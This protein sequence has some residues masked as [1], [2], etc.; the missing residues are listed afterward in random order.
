MPAP[1]MVTAA[2]V[3]ARHSALL[4]AEQERR[5]RRL[6]AMQRAPSLVDQIKYVFSGV[7]R[8]AFGLRA[9][10][11]ALAS[12][13]R[14]AL[15]EAAHCAQFAL[16]QL[17]QTY[18][19]TRKRRQGVGGARH[20]SWRCHRQAPTRRRPA[21]VPGSP[22]SGL[23]R[24]LRCATRPAHN[25]GASGPNRR[26]SR[27]P[28]IAAGQ[29]A[30]LAGTARV[31][32]GLTIRGTLFLSSNSSSTLSA[33]WVA[34][35]SGGTLQAGSAA[36]PVPAGITATIELQNG[37]AHP[38]A[39]RKALALLAGGTLEL[40]GAKGLA[41]PWAR[42]AA[43]AAKG[44]ATLHLDSDA[45]AAG[46]A[47]GDELAIASTDY[48][49]YQTE[50]VTITAG[51]LAENNVAVDIAGHAFFFEDGSETGNTLRGNLGML[52]R[53]KL[54]GARLGSDR[55]GPGGDLS[56][57]WIT[58]PDNTFEG[59]AAAATEGWG[60]FVHTRLAPRGLSAA[61]WPALAPHRTPL[62]SF[63]NNSAHSCRLC[64]E[65]EADAVD[66][67]DSLPVVPNSAPANW[68]PRNADGSWAEMRIEGFTCHHSFS[69]GMWVRMG[70]MR[71]VRT[72]WADQPEALQLA[73]TGTHIAPPGANALEDVLLVGVS[74]NVGDPEG[75][76]RFQRWDNRQGRSVAPQQ[77]I[78]S[79]ITGFKLYD[80]PTTIR[81][82]T[83]RSWPA[84]TA[85]LAVRSNNA[86]QMA[87]GTSVSGFR[88]ERVS[89]RFL[90][91]DSGGDGG[92]TTTLRDVD[93]SLS[94]Y[95]GATLLPYF[96]ASS[97]GFFSAPGCASHPAYG[98][99]CPHKYINLE[100]G[101]WDW[102]GGG[103]PAAIT[104]TH[105]NLSPGRA[106]AAQRLPSL[107]G[108]QLAQKSGRGGRYYNAAASV[109]GSYLVTWG[110]GSGAPGAPARAFAQCSSCGPGDEVE[111]I[112]CYPGGTT[113]GAAGVTRGSWEFLP[114]QQDAAA[115]AA[116]GSFASLAAMR[117]ATGQGSRYYFD[118]ASGLLFLRVQQSAGWGGQE[119]D[120][121][122]PPGGCAVLVVH[123][124]PAG[125]AHTPQQ[126]EAWL[127]A[128]PGGASTNAA[129][130]PFLSAALPAPLFNLTT[131]CPGLPAFGCDC[132][133]HTGC[134]SKECTAA[135]RACCDASVDSPLGPPS[136]PPLASP[137]PSSASPVP[138]SP[139]PPPRPSPPASATAACSTVSAGGDFCAPFCFTK[140]NRNFQTG[141]GF[142]GFNP[143]CKSGGLG[144]LGSQEGCRLCHLAGATGNDPYF[145]CPACVCEHY[146]LAPSLCDAQGRAGLLVV[147][148]P[149]LPKPPT[150][151]AAARPKPPP[152]LRRA[153]PPSLRP[154]HTSHLLKAEPVRDSSPSPKPSPRPPPPS[155]RPLK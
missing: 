88:P 39:G 125:A 13:A 3:S 142:L 122:C 144:C 61:S 23:P 85:P 147:P 75:D 120:G 12:A 28:D 37:S 136:P 25:S 94:G 18:T 21:A 72:A 102:A 92:R 54:S 60:F 77:E 155:T 22:G 67:G 130:D 76:P 100:L 19:V 115:E 96:P 42:L 139:N 66:G 11:Q 113:L 70:G 45:S 17:P 24:A 35:E 1:Q 86:F 78:A 135:E 6:Q 51:V 140:A 48:D 95:P 80:G 69:A 62:R 10:Q 82:L 5:S 128:L 4:P 53:P 79:V 103:S 74:G 47:A 36:C 46:W 91:Q 126:C 34:V 108:N 116:P 138:S 73:V 81:G 33:E 64:L 101:G 27:R 134:A 7:P 55:A 65:M 124:V 14:R 16:S 111:A 52:V 38:A 127:A 97:L 119:P 114:S 121:Y 71:F 26:L 133:G 110:A 143:S 141:V 49:P 118:A 146:G 40:H 137:P 30:L 41:L 149:P 151:P 43:T 145:V 106:L 112:V 107:Q 2:P 57:F 105:S 29:C 90:I 152:V 56:V 31:A 150:P 109:G 148:S 129:S 123:A 8:P 83:A 63:V 9:R 68:Q 89:Y 32:G 87:A 50:R 84:G 98:L 153:H 132:W 104:V 44:T 93:G 15:A 59:N 154:V 58:N 131:A 117:A 99:A 20:G